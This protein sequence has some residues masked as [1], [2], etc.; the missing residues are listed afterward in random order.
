MTASKPRIGYHN[1]FYL[2]RLDT[3]ATSEEDD[4][5]AANAVDF[6]F[7]TKWRPKWTNNLLANHD[8]LAWT[9]GTSA[10]PDDWTNQDAGAGSVGQDATNYKIAPFGC[11]L[12][13]SGGINLL[14]QSVD[15]AGAYAG[16][17]MAAGVWLK[18]S[19]A[20]AA[21]PYI[22]DG[23]SS[24]FGDYHTGG[25]D[26]E[27]ITV[28]YTIT[29]GATRA[30]FGVQLADGATVVIDGATFIEGT[31]A[32]VV[33]TPSDPEDA[34]LYVYPSDTTGEVAI[35]NSHFTAWSSGTLAPPDSWDESDADAVALAP[36]GDTGR[37]CA[38]VT[39][40]GAGTYRYATYT[41]DDETTLEKLRG[42]YIR[43]GADVKS[44]TASHAY[45]Q[46]AYRG[47]DDATTVPFTASSYHTGG[48]SFEWLT[49]AAAR[50]PYDATAVILRLAVYNSAAG[51]LFNKIRLFV[52]TSA[53]MSAPAEGP[54][55][56]A[57]TYFAIAGHNL[58]TVGAS[59]I[60]QSSAD[61]SS[62]TTRATLTPTNNRPAWVDFA[63][64]SAPWWRVKI[65]VATGK[66]RPEI[67]VIAAGE[68]L[69]MPEYPTGQV[70]PDQ[71]P[72]EAETYSTRYGTPVGASMKPSAVEHVLMFPWVT[73]TWITTTGTPSWV[74]FKRHAGYNPDGPGGLPFFIQ[75]DDGD[76]SDETWF[77]A[78]PPGF[79]FSEPREDGYDTP[80]LKLAMN[81]IQE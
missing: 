66:G 75:W 2:D 53:A 42:R 27:F 3:W 14:H 21:R 48:G 30:R 12:V 49:T 18:T 68:Y 25:G 43:M 59:A 54:D 73:D 40:A 35:L 11:E 77:G 76:H 33:E 36:G 61:G 41:I 5:P 24:S 44:S 8:M 45:L 15:T 37:Y 32:E 29:A 52:S 22:D 81:G 26:W 4:Y 10:A 20:S 6:R 34:Y 56:V 67:G 60:L 39:G 80:I 79:R 38:Q 57:C 70:D 13:A 74:E 58:G 69:E 72:C 63:E 16:K 64:V 51:A 9:A 19:T 50:I 7:G 55:S 62:W 17:T 78:L 65:D 28:E 23:V 47:R 1:I 71:W 46:T 31:A